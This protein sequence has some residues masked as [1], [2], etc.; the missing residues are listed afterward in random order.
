MGCAGLAATLSRRYAILFALPVIASVI[1]W[2]WWPLAWFNELHDVAGHYYHIPLLVKGG[3]LVPLA[4]SRW[5]RPEARLLLVMACAPQTMFNYDQLPLLLIARGR[6]Q[7]AAFALL[8][9]VPRW[10]ND[11]IYGP[12]AADR[13][14][15]FNH[16]APFIVACYYLPSLAIVLSRPNDCTVPPWLDRVM[17]RSPHWL[18]GEAVDPR[19]TGVGS[20]L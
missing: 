18:R 2:P 20:T 12:S 9:Y 14:A 16:L 8:S 4:L 5:R 19:R 13:E 7:V 11:I 6:I 17:M 10:L 1:V 15:L 3:F